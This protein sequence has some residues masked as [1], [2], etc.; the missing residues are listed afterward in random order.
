MP[1]ATVPVGTAR[2]GF[3]PR[4]TLMTP[5]SIP[6]EP[7]CKVPDVENPRAMPPTEARIVESGTAPSFSSRNTLPAGSPRQQA[8]VTASP[9]M[10][11]KTLP[12]APSPRMQSVASTASPLVSR[13]ATP[14]PSLRAQSLSVESA[15][16]FAFHAKVAAQPSRQTLPS[17]RSQTS[18][19][20]NTIVDRS[21]LQPSAVCNTPM[22]EGRANHDAQRATS[23]PAT[24][25]QRA[26]T[27][28]LTPRGTAPKA[29]ATAT[30]TARAISSVSAPVRFSYCPMASSPVPHPQFISQ[31]RQ[32]IYSSPSP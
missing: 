22:V 14:S 11:R 9:F 15:A 5:R 27:V 4:S 31:T 19:G 6:V 32:F 26:S 21:S 30:S 3:T 25:G 18:S 12:P 13:N 20:S 29:V 24:T 7:R 23:P 1:Q 28:I 2:Q 10:T 16:P 8:K 17:A